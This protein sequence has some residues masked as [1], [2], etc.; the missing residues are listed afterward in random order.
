MCIDHGELNKPLQREHFPLS[1]LED[2]LHEL[3]QSR[4]FSKVDLFSGYWHIE[5]DNKS[6]FLKT[7]QTCYGRYRGLRLRFKTKVSS[8]IFGKRLLDELAGLPG[9]IC[10][11]D[12]V[13]IHEANTEEREKNLKVLLSRCQEKGIKLNKVKLKL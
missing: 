7:F 13:I 12:D 6:S 1:I 5:L 8:E 11:A 10:T 2:S 4:I 3:G 9:I